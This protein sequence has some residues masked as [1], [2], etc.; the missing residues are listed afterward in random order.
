MEVTE[1]FN[2]SYSSRNTFKTCE[3]KFELDKLYPRRARVWEDTYAADVGNALHRGYQDFLIHRDPDQ[4]TWALMQAFPW[5]TEFSQEKDD[6]KFEAVLSTFD[7]M[8]DT[9]E[10]D[11]YELA[12]IRRPNTPEEIA[13]G[14]TDGVIVPA[15]EVPF[16]IRFKNLILPDGRGIQY[17]GY[18][19]AIMRNLTT[20]IHRTLDIKTTRMHVADAT[21]KYLFNDQ[22]VPYGIVIEH[23]ANAAVDKF[24]VLYLDCYIDLTEPDVK[25]YPFTK[26]QTD[27]QE[28]MIGVAIT[29]QQLRQYMEASF[30]PRTGNGCMAFS[31]PCR[32]MEVCQ[33]RDKDYITEWF[34]MGEEPAQR[35]PF[36]PW[37]VADLEIG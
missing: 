23:V 21:G 10:L 32:H 24:E 12:K 37:I 28:W 3:R 13:A 9:T 31:K 16:A 29:A 1:Y 17:T 36:H 33:S 18:I 2:I 25:L 20:D 34:L 6:R 27:I 26:T 11:D 30:F 4:A 8:L 7:T 15:I 35:E 22:Q 19:D 14:L 5:D